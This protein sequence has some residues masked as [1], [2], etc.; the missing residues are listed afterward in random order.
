MFFVPDFLQHSFPH[1]SPEGCS[2]SRL[3]AAWWLSEHLIGYLSCCTSEISHGAPKWSSPG[4]SKC[5]SSSFRPHFFV[6]FVFQPGVQS[7]SQGKNSKTL[8]TGR[9]FLRECRRNGRRTP[10]VGNAE[11]TLTLSQSWP[12]SSPS[13]L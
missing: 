13:F 5:G 4:I 8:K 3:V 6:F 9:L 2:G 1:H 10:E 11:E 7:T 12:D